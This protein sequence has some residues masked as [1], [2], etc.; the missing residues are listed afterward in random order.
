[1]AKGIAI[2]GIWIG[3]GIMS[4]NL[5]GQNMNLAVCGAALATFLVAFFV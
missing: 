2:T 4:F 5:T 1:M 3:L